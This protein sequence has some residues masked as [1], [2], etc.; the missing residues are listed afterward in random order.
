[1]AA[2]N[3]GKIVFMLSSCTVGMPPNNLSEYTMVKYALLGMMKSIAVEYGDKGININAVSP[4][5]IETKF[6]KNIGRKMREINAELN[7]RHRNLNV[8]D[9]IPAIM[10][11]LSDES[12]FVNGINLSLSSMG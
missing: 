2:E 4:A 7:P 10:Y 8:D 5:M 9:V 11:L 6:V 12:K 1:M 3:Y